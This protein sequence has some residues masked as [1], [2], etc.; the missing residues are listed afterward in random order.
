MSDLEDLVGYKAPK[1]TCPP[2]ML[3]IA[4]RIEEATLKFIGDTGITPNVV[5]LGWAEIMALL[6]V[7]I[8]GM[9][10]RVPNVLEPSA[11]TVERAS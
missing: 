1:P 4:L 9:R 8:C 6:P 2:A 5:T 3:D 10:V 7:V 11:V